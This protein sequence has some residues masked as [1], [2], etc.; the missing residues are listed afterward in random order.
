MKPA[1]IAAGSALAG[2]AIAMTLAFALPTWSDRDSDDG[3]PAAD[4][5]APPAMDGV[6][7][8]GKS[9]QDNAGIRIVTLAFARAGMLRSGLARALDIGALSAIYSEISS[10]GAALDAS[11]ADYARQRALAAADQ[12]ASTRAVETARAQALADQARLDVAAR[13]IG[14]EFGPGLSS[15]SPAALGDLVRAVAAGQASL[16]RI[17]FSDG[18]APRGTLVQI[19]DARES[20]TVRLLGAAAAADA[21]LQSVGQLAVVRGPLAK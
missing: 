19:G 12:S 7:T 5:G 4:K 13:R 18:P 2:A 15:F 3:A 21:R 20:T 8:L 10:A 17:D 11:R 16:I 1:L 9:V 14:L 6:V